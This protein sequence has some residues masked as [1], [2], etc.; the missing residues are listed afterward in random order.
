MSYIDCNVK[1]LRETA[2]AG[3]HVHEGQTQGNRDFTCVR[4]LYNIGGEL[5]ES[6]V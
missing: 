4:M 1:S 6:A 2:R 5:V 3:E